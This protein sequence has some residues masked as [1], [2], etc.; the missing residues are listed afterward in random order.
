MLF[1][2]LHRAGMGPADARDR[3][4]A[5]LDRAADLTSSEPLEPSL[6]GGYAGVAWT[7]THLLPHLYDTDAEDPAGDVDEALLEVLGESPWSGDYDLIEGLVGLG[8]YALERLPR[9]AARV[10]LER[11]IDRLAELSVRSATG[12]TWN[13][14]ARLLLAMQREAFP[15]G[16]FNVG[17]AH[18]VPGVIALLGSVHAAGVRPAGARDL[19]DGA[20]AWTLSQRLPGGSG[21]RLPAMVP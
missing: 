4:C 2:T 9:P 13:T 16:F 7:M 15:E 14:P 8:V 3:A 18:G 19:L 6:F 10:C 12:V 20:V 5:W 1:A 21:S 17:V 11:C